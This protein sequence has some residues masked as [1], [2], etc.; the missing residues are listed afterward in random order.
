MPNEPQFEPETDGDP[1]TVYEDTAP[2]ERYELGVVAVTRIGAESPYEKQENDE[3]E[4]KRPTRY[5]L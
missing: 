5:R 1:A 2:H 3:Q 4:Q